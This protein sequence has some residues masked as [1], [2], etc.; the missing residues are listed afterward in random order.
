MIFNQSG[1]VL[2]L[3]L[4]AVALFAA[5]S[6]AV[7]QSTSTS[8]NAPTA[9]KTRLIVSNLYNLF[10]QIDGALIRLQADGSCTDQ[11]IGLDFVTQLTN[12]TTVTGNEVI[13]DGTVNGNYTSSWGQNRPLDGS[14]DI[15]GT[16]GGKVALGLKQVPGNRLQLFQKEFTFKEFVFAGYQSSNLTVAED[17]HL[18]IMSSGGN[19]DNAVLEPICKLINRDA[20]LPFPTPAGEYPGWFGAGV[21]T[22]WGKRTYCLFDTTPTNSPLIIHIVAER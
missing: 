4:I 16:N 2:F 15:F 12:G 6:Y 13:G 18:W 11:E 22:F 21:G 9:E 19:E 17:L 20:S 1:N 10:S 3:I 8:G 7:T 5:L 14:C